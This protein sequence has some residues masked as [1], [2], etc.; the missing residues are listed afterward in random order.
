MKFVALADGTRDGRLY[1]ASRDNSRVVPAFG[2]NTLQAALD[3]WDN[4]HA[5]LERQYTALNAENLDGS[6]AFDPTQA[7]AP[8]PRAW[9]WLDGSAFASHGEL[10]R[11]VFGVNFKHKLLKRTFQYEKVL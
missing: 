3:Q 7:M 5:D 11:Q 10:M 8:L 4:L 2:V 1:I 6:I 9:Q